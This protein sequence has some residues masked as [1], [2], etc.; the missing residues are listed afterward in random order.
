MV[1]DMLRHK[2]AI[3]GFWKLPVLL[4]AA[5]L[6]WVPAP[7]HAQS[8]DVTN[9]YR[10]TLFPFHKINDHLTGFGYL[11]YVKNPDSDYSLYYMGWPGLNY[12]A[13]KWL[14]IWVGF[15]YI[16]T[17][18]EFKADKFELRP[19]VGPKIFLPNKYKM[20]LYNFTRY[21][22]R[23]TKDR[24]TDQ[25]TTVHRIRSRFRAEIPLTSLEKA[26]KPKTF[27]GIGDVEPFFRSD[28][29]ALDPFRLRAGLGYV[30]NDRL[31][32]E[33]I[34]HAQFGRATTDDPLEYNQNI[35][36]LN[37][38][39]GLHQGILDRNQNPGVDE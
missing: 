4:W 11:G 9:E 5:V 3:R 22:Y 38:K 19:F 8:P 12:Q 37:F 24:A 15:F 30:A 35:F 32:V 27:Y 10:V 34:Y 33:F 13:K 6:I 39:L 20:N 26:W 29:K 28:K 1:F 14:Q 2:R 7:I 36:R 17:N 31:R 21:E 16:Y 23:R 18:N 25:W